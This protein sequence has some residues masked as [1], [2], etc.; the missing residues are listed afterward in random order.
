MHMVS[1]FITTIY[2]AISN[3]CLVGTLPAGFNDA[4]LQDG[5]SNFKQGLRVESCQPSPSLGTVPPDPPSSS[6]T[7]TIPGAPPSSSTSAT[8]TSAPPSTTRPGQCSNAPSTVVVTVTVTQTPPASTPTGGGGGGG[9]GNGG[10][11]TLSLI[12]I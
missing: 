11:G 6:T 9:G 2:D 12:H 8:I 7:A 3:W 1:G 4:L 5:L 10:G